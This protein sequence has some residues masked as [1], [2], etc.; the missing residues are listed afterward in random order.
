[1]ANPEN[2]RAAAYLAAKERMDL[3]GFKATRTGKTRRGK[4]K[5]NPPN[6]QCG[7]R[8][9]PPNWDCRLKGEGTNSE[10]NVH[11]SDPLAGI[12]SIQR[13]AKDLKQGIVTVNPARVQRGRS[14]IIR[15]VVKIAPGD[16]LEAKKRLRKRLTEKT[17]PIMAVIGVG[18]LTVAV[19]AGLKKNFKGYRDGPGAEV[20]RAAASAFDTFLDHV[21]VVRGNRAARR[22]AGASAIGS[23]GGSVLR[24]RNMEAMR[25]QAREN[26]RRIGPLSHAPWVADPEG[27]GLTGALTAIDSH[28]RERRRSYEEWSQDSVHTL[29]SASTKSRRANNTTGS[30]FSENAANEF[31]SSKFGL[32]RFGANNSSLSTPNRNALIESQLTQRLGEWGDSMREDMKLRRMVGADGTI[33][34]DHVDRYIREV[35]STLAP[36]QL[37]PLPRQ[38]RAAARTQ[39][40]N[41]IRSAILGKDMAAEASSIRKET[42]AFYDNYFA[43][44]AQRMRRNAAAAD[45]PFGDGLTAYARYVTSR[46]NSGFGARIMS[47]DHA[48]LILRQHYHYDVMRQ[49]GDFRVSDNTA[50]RVAQQITRSADLPS[51]DDAF[52]ILQTNGLPRASRTTNYAAGKGPPPRQKARTLAEIAADIRSRPG[53]ENMSQNAS[54]QA[55]RR[56]RDANR[57][58]AA[59]A[60]RLGKPCGA[61]H[62]PKAH[63]CNKGQGSAA[64]ATPDKGPKSSVSVKTA[65]L[66]GA[67]VALGAMVAYGAA[68]KAKI[69]EYR[70]HTSDSALK[71]ETLAKEMM[72]EMRQQ[73]AKRTGKDAKDVTGFEASVYNFKDKGFDRGFGSNDT[74]PAYFGQTPN[75]RGAVVMLSYADD[76]KFTKRGQGSYK[77]ATGGAFRE[78]WGE[79]DILPFANNISQP[80]RRGPDDLT[81]N[82]QE[83]LVEK[84]GP[85][86]DAIKTAVFFKE[87]AK[88]FD[89]LKENIDKRGFNPDAVRAAAFVAAQRRLTGKPV[90]I[91]AYSNGGNV[92][93][94]TLAILKEMGYRDVKVVNVAGPTFGVF[95]HGR[96]N[97]RTW[98]SPGDEFWKY[99]KGSAFQGGN[100]TLL[101]N[102]NIPHGLT[103][104]IDPNNRE[105]GANWKENLKQKNSYLKD[106]QL[107][108]EAH[109]FLTVDK[110]R[111]Q[112]LSDEFIWRVASK[113]PMEGDLS[114][115]LGTNST[116]IAARYTKMRA[117]NSRLADEW[118]RDQIEEG[119]IDKWYGGYSAAAVKNAQRQIKKDLEA[120]I[121]GVKPERIDAKGKKCGNSYIPRSHTCNPDE[122]KAPNRT[123]TAA[124]IALAAGV[125]AA[126][127]YALKK[128]QLG[129]YHTGTITEKAGP[130]IRKRRFG[131][132]KENSPST[133]TAELAAQFIPLKTQKSVIPENVDALTSFIKKEKVTMNAAAFMKDL[134]DGLKKSGV[135]PDETRKQ[136]VATVNFLA[137]VGVFD[138]LA[139]ITSNNIFV[140]STRKNLDRL[141]TTPSK[142][143]SAAGDFMNRRAETP[144]TTPGS[145]EFKSVFHVGKSAN[146]G[147]TLEYLTTIHEV[148]HLVHFKASRKK[149]YTYQ[150]MIGADTFYQP[151]LK[152]VSDSQLR[153]ALTDAASEYGRSDVAAKRC[154]TF[155]ELSVLYVT[156]GV[157]FKREHP[158]AYAWVDDIWKTANG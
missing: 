7:N 68:N 14:S 124:K 6:V 45:S 80:T 4:L 147:D 35:G 51:A 154:E 99:A 70:S 110:Q 17:T 150:M 122:N 10:L 69:S 33:N 155:S 34:K 62:I 13:G 135:M 132:M 145:K 64:P 156:Q 100:V 12:A 36:G 158:I 109:R 43:D 117:Q 129:Q 119:M 81:M 116:S 66:V 96:D 131:Y 102:K 148:S 118:L 53:N 28:T 49:S 37:N 22:A 115:V 67:G 46:Q 75:S 11:K 1:M 32:P 114:A 134:E 104:K 27:S 77:M 2:I 9:I 125:V 18:L 133:S 95:K 3:R 44:V 58:G 94:E 72:D 151:K 138:G 97:M 136:A 40:N 143:V 60:Q 130:G 41:L 144:I 30:I 29:F 63:N 98:V 42:V 47:R 93:S 141:D 140:R 120:Q 50:R 54:M 89:Y 101:K 103:E 26:M 82:A 55:A 74:S 78:I 90:H 121:S 87:T 8:C 108:R 139:P 88:N 85:A 79:H 52:R 71:A 128:A 113:K 25:E 149:G 39:T 65:A 48:D 23:I 5:C 146:D 61:S 91:M 92:A 19:H 84:A 106:E 142:V 153:K 157:R 83:R 38:Q 24:G 31:I 137:H 73:A 127:V 59:G 57:G 21:P 112:E 20:D 15:G 86:G 126:G 152:D 56:E 105:H 76:N 123:K 111:S 16:N 107:Q